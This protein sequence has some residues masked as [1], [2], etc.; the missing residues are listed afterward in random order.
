MNPGGETD[1]TRPC[2]GRGLGST[3][4]WGSFQSYCHRREVGRELEVDDAGAGR[5]GDRLQPGSKQVRLLPASLCIFPTALCGTILFLSTPPD[6]VVLN[7]LQECPMVV[8]C[9]ILSVTIAMLMGPS[10]LLAQ[11]KQPKPVPNSP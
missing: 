5:P 7:S 10:T 1:I 11:E 9:C 6:P 8:R 3:P 2:E 4:G